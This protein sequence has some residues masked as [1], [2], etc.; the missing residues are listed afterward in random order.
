MSELETTLGISLV[1]VP[2]LHGV[3]P[4]IRAINASGPDQFLN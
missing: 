3:E 2:P 1:S 4:R